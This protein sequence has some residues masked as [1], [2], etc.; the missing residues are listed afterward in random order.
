MARAMRCQADQEQPTRANR[1]ATNAAQGS[2][3]PAALPALQLLIDP[4][5]GRVLVRDRGETFGYQLEY[6][7]GPG[8]RG[9]VGWVEY[10]TDGRG[11]PVRAGVSAAEVMAVTRDAG[12]HEEV[13][14]L[15]EW[16][17]AEFDRPDAKAQRQAARLLREVAAGRE[18]ERVSLRAIRFRIEQRLGADDSV[19]LMCKRGGFIK[20]G[21]QRSLSWL[22]RRAGLRPE[23]WSD[24]RLRRARTA[25][26]PIFL[27]L[28]A[29]V[30]AS[31]DE[32]GV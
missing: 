1:W 22:E 13:A 15:T 19:A 26:Y 18:L 10:A 3:S 32:F 28:V 27:R 24:G 21:R 2:A 29:A 14:A 9:G 31:P 23:R 11:A 8:L 16:A 25:S 17:A 20:Q 7:A 12:R 4:D 30:G 5:A 6:R